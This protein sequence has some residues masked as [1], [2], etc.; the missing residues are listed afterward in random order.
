[1]DGVKYARLTSMT[2]KMA[3]AQAYS[4]ADQAGTYEVND[5]PA[6][7]SNA[8]TKI[9]AVIVAEN[10][11]KGDLEK[12]RAYANAVCGLT[13]YNSDAAGNPNTPYGDPWQLVYIFD[14]DEG[15]KVVCEGYSKA[16][17]YLCDL[18]D[19][20]GEVYCELMGGAIPAGDH[21]WNAVRMPDGRCYPVDLTN[22]DGGDAC[23]ER[24]FPE[25]MPRS[26]GQR[27]HL[28]Y[29]QIHL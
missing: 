17:K 19:F 13:A 4:R 8:V 5:L 23:N 16:F 12:L 24:V 15:T 26:V 6:R 10:K 2:A 9:K 27:L 3:V 29:A 21:M 7:V 20:D 14:G 1:M 22:S 18:S 28:R 11:G 25:G